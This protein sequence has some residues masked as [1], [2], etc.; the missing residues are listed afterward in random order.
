MRPHEQGFFCFVDRPGD[1]FRWGGENVSAAEF[2]GVVASCPGVSDAAAQGV[3][4]CARMSELLGPDNPAQSG[5]TNLPIV[6]GLVIP[7][8]AEAYRARR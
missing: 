3:Q 2:T 1:T 4:R 7:F 6:T 5:R 8:L